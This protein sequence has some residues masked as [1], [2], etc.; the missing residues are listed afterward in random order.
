[1]LFELKKPNPAHV[2]GAAPPGN[3]P[4]HFIEPAIL[5][6]PIYINP[7]LGGSTFFSKCDRTIDGIPIQDSNFDGGQ[8]MLYHAANRIFTSDAVR[9]E[10]YGDPLVWISN[11]SERDYTEAVD[12]VQGKP[13]IPAIPAGPN[14]IPPAIPAQ[15]ATPWVVGRPIWRHPNLAKA[16]DPIIFDS[17]GQSQPGMLSFGFDGCFPFSCQNNTL[18]QLT[19]QKLENGFLHPGVEFTF[20]LHRRE[21][22]LA[23]VERANITDAMYFGEEA[24]ANNLVTGQNRINSCELTIKAVFLNYESVFLKSSEQIERFRKSTSRYCADIV[25]YRQN[26][27]A[28]GVLHDTKLISLPAGTKLVYLMWIYE[29]QIT[30]GAQRNSY[31]SARFRFPPLLEQLNL[32][33]TGM[34]GLLVKSG[35][36]N[37]GRKE[38]RGSVSLKIYH[39]DLMRKA[40]YTKPFDSFFPPW[41]PDDG[42]NLGYDQIIVLD[43]TPYNIPEG[44]ELS[45]QMTYNTLARQR[46]YLR[47]Y[48]IKQRIFEYNERSKWTFKDV[49]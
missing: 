13:D 15:A 35:L 5:Q 4:M 2:P 22:L 25:L 42:G 8:E 6:P 39:E 40:I 11:R 16:M 44:A 17:A 23:A 10:K 26:N 48:H 29:A 32:T 36:S 12:E 34:D 7:L 9:K 38:G 1:V 37:L 47:S 46:W 28:S 49:A 3:L 24:I 27:L 30:Y 14:G 31:L 18:R 33:L 45:V 20:C 19:G 43:L 21:P 41:R